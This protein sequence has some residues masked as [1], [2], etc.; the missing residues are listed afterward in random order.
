MKTSKQYQPSLM[1]L[2]AAA[3][4]IG[5][6]TIS[7]GAFAARGGI[8]GKPDT[9]GGGG[10]ETPDLGDIVILYRDADGLPIP[11]AATQVPDPESGQLVDAGLCQQPIGL[12]SDT[13]TLV[14][15]DPNVPCL[16]PVDPLTCGVVAEYA[17]CPQEVDFGRTSVVRSPDSVLEQA[18]EEATAK[19]A[20]AQCL[21]L[22]PAGR[23]VTTSMV[24]NEILS[25]AIDS[26]LENLAI[27]WQLL[28]TGYLGDAA[29]PIV[30]PD[31]DILT[32]AARGFG[33][34]ADKTGEVTVDQIVYANQIMGLLDENA[35]TYLLKK[36]VDVRE[37]VQGTVQL[38]EKC[39]L[40]LSSYQYDRAINFTSLPNPPYIPAGDPQ[41]GWFEYLG[42]YS[43]VPLLFEIVQGPILETVFGTDPGFL[44]GNVGGFSQAADDTREVIE[45]THDRPL[46]LGYDTPVPLSCEVS[47]EPI[48]DV[49]ISGDSGLQVPVRMVIGTEGREV[50]VTVAN[51][52][53]DTA[54]GTVSVVGKAT[55]GETV[56]S[57]SVPFN[58]AAETSDETTWTFTLNF[59]TTV[60]WTATATPDCPAC[61]LNSANNSVTETTVV[62]GKGGGSGGGGQ[63]N[64]PNR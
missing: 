54:T 4:F 5:L 45:F 32:T 48:Y 8:P 27:Y 19:L 20:T 14:C 61:D 58:L 17:T 56:F 42:L 7:V 38:V 49:S 52:G 47:E 59:A 30:L 37:E 21:S 15:A 41:E 39:V 51:S 18:L 26:P 25:A 29:N 22:D 34:A 10:G 12:P 50:I 46:P 60:T 35:Q 24:D 11:T 9:S 40:D 16:V 6:F 28:R 33:A 64:N 13:C 23:L 2:L 43:E 1:G 44:N 63:G 55:N 57:E 53:P 3:I 36:C 31:P 62:T